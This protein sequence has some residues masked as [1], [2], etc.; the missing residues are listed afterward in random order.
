M[1]VMHK[2]AMMRTNLTMRRPNPRVRACV[3]LVGLQL[4][5]VQLTEVLSTLCKNK[6]IPT[7]PDIYLWFPHVQSETGGILIPMSK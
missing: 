6:Y 5:S 4:T 3:V 2:V 7:K 1:V